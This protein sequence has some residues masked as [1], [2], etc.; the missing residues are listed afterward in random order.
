MEKKITEKLNALQKYIPFI[1]FIIEIDKEKYFKFIEIRKWIINKTRYPLGDLNKIEQSIIIQYKNIIDGKT[2]KIPQEIEQIFNICIDLSSDD[3]DVPEATK[4]NGVKKENKRVSESNCDDDDDIEIVSYIKP[5]PQN[6][7]VKKEETI[8]NQALDDTS[9]DLLNSI[10]GFGSEDVTI[11]Q[12]L[13]PTDSPIKLSTCKEAEK[14]KTTTS[15]DLPERRNSI[16]KSIVS[17]HGSKESANENSIDKAKCDE[18]LETISLD[19]S[20]DEDTHEIDMAKTESRSDNNENNQISWSSNP[21]EESKLLFT[22]LSDVKQKQQQANASNTTNI[23]PTSNSD[24]DIA[25]GEKH[26]ENIPSPDTS[27]NTVA[28][29]DSKHQSHESTKETSVAK[30]NDDSSTILLDSK[31]LEKLSPEEFVNQISKVVDIRNLLTSGVL[32]ELIKR[33]PPAKTEEKST[34][35][36]SSSNA[37][38][39]HVANTSQTNSGSNNSVQPSNKE[40]LSKPDYESPPPPPPLL[41]AQPLSPLYPNVNANYQQSI[42]TPPIPPYGED[43]RYP[44]TGQAYPNQKRLNV[45]DPRIRNLLNKIKNSPL[46][47]ASDRATVNASILQ[48]TS[49]PHVYNAAANSFVPHPMISNQP[50]N[51]CHPNYPPVQRPTYIPGAENQNRYRAP[52]PAPGSQM[53]SHKNRPQAAGCTKSSITYLEYKQRKEREKLEQEIKERQEIERKRIEA[54]KRQQEEEKR[55]QEALDSATKRDSLKKTEEIRSI[56]LDTLKPYGSKIESM[57]GSKNETLKCNSTTHSSPKSP[58]NDDKSMDTTPLPTT[59]P[60]KKSKEKSIE[61]QKIGRT[62]RVFKSLECTVKGF[63]DLQD[64]IPKTIGGRRRSSMHARTAITEQLSSLDDGELSS[65]QS[66]T[67][68]FSVKSPIAKRRKTLDKCNSD[69]R[70]RRQSASN[71]NVSTSLVLHSDSDDEEI[72]SISIR[73]RQNYRIDD[74][75][76]DNECQRYKEII[77]KQPMVVV[78]RLTEQEIRKHTMSRH[79]DNT[80]ENPVLNV[81]LVASKT[82]NIESEENP[83]KTSTKAGRKA[84]KPKKRNNDC[85]MTER[86]TSFCALCSSKPSDLTNHYIKKHKSE[87]YVSRLTWSQ[88]DDLCINTQFAKAVASST[89]SGFIRYT[90]KCPFCDDEITEPFMKLYNHFSTHTGEY[91][92]QCSNCQLEQPYRVHIESHQL[93]H[94]PCKS[95]NLQILY[96]YPPN[97][98]VIY[99]HYCTICNFVQL[100]EA[101]ILKHLREHHDERQANANNVGKCILVAI[102][103]GPDISNGKP[104]EVLGNES[105]RDMSP[106]LTNVPNDSVKLENTSSEMHANIDDN[107][108]VCNEAVNE[109]ELVDPITMQL[110]K[111]LKAMHDDSPNTSNISVPMTIV[112]MDKSNVCSGDGQNSFAGKHIPKILKDEPL[113]IG[114]IPSASSPPPPRPIPMEAKVCPN[115]TYSYRSNYRDYPLNVKYLGLFKCLADDCYYSTDSPNEMLNHLEDHGNQDIVMIPDDYLQCAYCINSEGPYR[116]PQQLVDHIQE[117]HLHMIYQCSICCYRSCEPYNVVLHQ[118]ANHSNILENCRVYKG[119]GVDPTTHKYQNLNDKIAENV[120]KLQCI[121]CNNKSFYHSNILENHI[122][123]DHRIQLQMPLKYSSCI[124]CSMRDCD[125]LLMRKH[126]AIKHPEDLPYICSHNKPAIEGEDFL[127]NLQPFTISQEVPVIEVEPTLNSVIR[128]TS[129]PMDQDIKPNAADLIK[130]QEEIVANRIRKLTQKTGVTPDC[131]YH[132]PEHS[133]GGFFSNYDLWLHHMRRKHCCF[134]CQCPHC[135]TVLPLEQFQWHFENHRSHTYICFHCPSTFRTKQE[136]FDHAGN[137]HIA[138]GPMRLEVIPFHVNFSYSVIIQN[139]LLVDRMEFMVDFLNKLDE[140]LKEM[141]LNES[142]SLKYSWLVSVLY[143]TWLEDYP[144]AIN[145]KLKKKCFTGN[146]DF[147]TTDS[148]ILYQH[149]RD[150]HNIKGSTFN[151]CHCDFHIERCQQWDEVLNHI[152]NHSDGSF[153]ICGA[154]YTHHYTRSKI[155]LHIRQ[156]HAARDVPTINLI[157]ENGQIYF[158]LSVVFANECLS[159]STLRNCFCCEERGMK[160]DAFISHLKRYHNFVLK[161][162]CEWCNSPLDSLQLAQDHYR[163]I[164]TVN[165]LKIRCEFG[166]KND[167]SVV[168]IRNFQLRF[169]DKPIAIKQEQWSQDPDD[170]VILMEDDD[171]VVE[172]YIREKQLT[173]ETIEKPTL[174]CIPTTNLLNP[175]V[176]SSSPPNNLQNPL[177]VIRLPPNIK[178]VPLNNGTGSSTLPATCSSVNSTSYLPSYSMAGTSHS[179]NNNVAVSQP[180]STSAVHNLSSGHIYHYSNSIHSGPTNVNSVHSNT[181]TVENNPISRI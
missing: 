86:N 73:K 62:N 169:T 109:D 85:E 124:Y 87:S 33:L 63:D 173:E 156:E 99:L 77:E 150:T 116:T 181:T 140:R 45:N 32:V 97:S 131:L 34:E 15:T 161:Y 59:S 147:A 176:V 8:I 43:Y 174:K 166:C 119:H 89:K 54:D 115:K 67:N 22:R 157:Q 135:S 103:D 133:C 90:V 65:S 163:N 27:V 117:H 145:R 46:L 48:Q 126:V 141:E 68:E 74:E 79:Q 52:Y 41:S 88:L 57:W 171:I 127:H 106:T 31:S 167:L 122:R 14:Q 154:C 108:P 75:D 9:R 94:K 123:M 81:Q 164:H 6:K 138:L 170:S 104:K 78:T 151:C 29:I 3:E 180:Q 50:S 130:C 136:T 98:M 111:Q 128:E 96:R 125:E 39:D 58:K 160:S 93:Q 80:T 113:D 1:D 53:H 7:T 71:G 61:D 40:M 91:A 42:A 149:V 177:R 139:Q 36:N 162:F 72:Q 47:S 26:K 11:K 82:T 56:L 69:G 23:P 120:K 55:L 35:S 179:F 112:H 44:S 76:D 132:C 105:N 19:S 152:R 10:D 84:A 51:V 18:P 25:N 83:T 110:N 168:S 146:C 66:T 49:L 21:E 92:Y 175:S 95:S 142:K 137:V 13:S 114:H 100:N 101:N 4:P 129:M 24:I 70:K 143:S 178:I 2:A 17:Q 159:F 158:S 102:N 38:A 121:Y 148:E 37:T 134:E 118:E 5:E 155:A 144:R 28:N 153:F 64:Y 20:D 30:S 107:I 16:D 12:S 165:K 60:K 172:N